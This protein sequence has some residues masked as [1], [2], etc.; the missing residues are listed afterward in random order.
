[1][2]EATG[3]PVCGCEL[4]PDLPGGLCPNC[5]FSQG[6]D[7]PDDGPDPAAG[8]AL[9]ATTPQP[10]AFVPPDVRSL[11]AL[12]PQL[13]LLGLIGHGGMGAVYKARQKKLDRLVALKIIHP[14]S[15]GDPAFAERF[16]REARTLA[17]LNHPHIVAVHDFGEVTLSG[18]DAANSPPQT[19]YYFLME[20][21][22]GVNLRQAMA[23]NRLPQEQAL[24]IVSQVCDALQFA[25][26]AGVV[27][28]DIKPENILL[29]QRGRVKIADFGLA[30]LATPSELDFTLTATHQ[31]MGTPRYM[32]PEQMAGSHAV[33]HRADLYS[34]GAVLYEMLTGRVPIGHFEPPSHTAQVDARLDAIVFQALASDPE[35]RFQQASELK[36]RVDSLAGVASAADGFDS[37]LAP[38]A[39]SLSRLTGFSTICDRQMVAAW[40]WMKGD[41]SAL[42]S[43]DRERTPQTPP[44][45]G[46]LLIALAVI[47]CLLTFTP[48]ITIVVPVTASIAHYQTA[49]RLAEPTTLTVPGHNIVTGIIA[50]VMFAAFALLLLMTSASHAPGRARAIVMTVISL[51]ALVLLLFA[52][53]EVDFNRSIK[54]PILKPAGSVSA[55]VATSD[56]DSSRQAATDSPMVRDTLQISLRGVERQ[57]TLQLGYC[58]AVT[59]AIALL[60]L[61]ALG[62][63]HAFA[64]AVAQTTPAETRPTPSRTSGAPLANVRFRVEATVDVLP[65]ARFHFGSLGYEL[66]RQD[67]E[68]CVFQRGHFTSALTETDIRLYPTQLTVRLSPVEDGRRWVSCHWSVRLWGAWI[69]RKDIRTL[70]EEGR[71]FEALF[72]PVPEDAD[73]PPPPP[74][75][76]GRVSEPAPPREV[77]ALPPRVIDLDQVRSDVDGPSLALLAVGVLT[78]IGHAVVIAICLSNTHDRELAWI[79]V[80][81]LLPGL[82]MIVGGLH[83]RNLSSR[84]WAWIG[85]I[86]AVTPATFGW[87]LTLPIGVWVIVGA[88]T[89]PDVKQAFLETARRRRNPPA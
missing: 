60:V 51:A 1:M 28:R 61:S 62:V 55:G 72:H 21:V 31:V 42:E 37:V 81:G 18:T 11:A 4:P 66:A 44:F 26:D 71:Q 52:P 8:W 63:R 45:P 36:R 67:D 56:S 9:A 80:P 79:G 41:V 20:Y 24:A 35:R 19:L 70:E 82:A 22:D 46:L 86:A 17:R 73:A 76:V 14:E 32:A 68:H 5:L 34:L 84:G 83:L 27:H 38:S 6:L 16:N 49:G 78:C 54:L 13:E 10:G 59:M 57:S 87:L 15:A 65:Q 74:P 33:D 77:T 50:G 47:G 30:K 89:Q 3:C 43:R 2:S 48:W 58:G 88:L 12:F 75:F 23:A 64:A 40:R 7:G 69:G 85:A 29:D 53:T 39:T 25:H